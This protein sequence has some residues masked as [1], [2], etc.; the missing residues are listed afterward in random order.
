MK[1]KEIDSLSM[2]ECRV[3][4]LLENDCWRWGRVVCVC[5]G[6][7]NSRQ[8]RVGGACFLTSKGKLKKQCIILG[9]WDQGRHRGKTKGKR[10]PCRWAEERKSLMNKSHLCRDLNGSSEPW[11][12][13]ERLWEHKPGMAQT[14]RRSC[15]RPAVRGRSC[16]QRWLTA[17]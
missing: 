3:R 13:R 12:E 8:K 1:E 16:T 7:S 2:I 6:G 5:H 10:G 14:P 17:R 11:A 4:C 9:R 15:G